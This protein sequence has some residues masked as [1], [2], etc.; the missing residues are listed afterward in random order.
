MF[1]AESPEASLRLL[2]VDHVRVHLAG[3]HGFRQH[4]RIDLKLVRDEHA[5]HR[6]LSLL[7][8]I[9]DAVEV[10]ERALPL[11]FQSGRSGI[12]A[13]RQASRFHLTKSFGGERTGRKP[14]HCNSRLWLAG[15]PPLP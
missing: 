6:Q 5:R 13:Y 9:H 4:V 12:E 14:V 7:T 1:R 10:A 11:F 2:Q 3:L 15:S 8:I